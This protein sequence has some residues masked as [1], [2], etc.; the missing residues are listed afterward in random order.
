MAKESVAP[1]GAHTYLLEEPRPSAVATLFRRSAAQQG[2]GYRRDVLCDQRL[3]QHAIW[4]V[5]PWKGGDYA[6]PSIHSHLQSPRLP[7]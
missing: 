6:H 7:I 2:R 1:Y 3:P 4:T 5:L